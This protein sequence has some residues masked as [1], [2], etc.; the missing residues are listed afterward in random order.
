[1]GTNLAS[2]I[3]ASGASLSNAASV[4]SNVL[5]A[6]I[7]DGWTAAGM[8]FQG[9]V[10]GVSFYDLYTSSGSLVGVSP[11]AGA[12]V[13]TQDPLAFVPWTYIKAKSQS[14]GSAV[15]QTASRTVTFVFSEGL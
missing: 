5:L 9:S 15:N 8:S 13:Q 10:D 14:G 11:V 6:V 3:I 4:S 2:V 1:M 7:V 12:S